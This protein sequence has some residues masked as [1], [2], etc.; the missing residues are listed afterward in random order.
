M[1]FMEP[2]LGMMY[3][4]NKAPSPR[5]DLRIMHRPPTGSVD[6]YVHT[7]LSVCS[8]AGESRLPVRSPRH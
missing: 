3:G 4:S 2:G 6:E 1:K 7:I 8:D 5:I